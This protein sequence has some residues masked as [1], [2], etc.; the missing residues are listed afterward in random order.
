[1]IRSMT[2]YGKAEAVLADKKLIIEIK[3]LN[4]KSNDSFVKLPNAYRSKEIELRQIIADRLIRGKIDVNFSQELNTELSPAAIN[5]ELVIAYYKQLEEINREM[6]IS[7]GINLLDVV[8][9]LP[10]AVKVEK[11]EAD[12]NEWTLILEALNSAV[13]QLNAFREREGKSLEKDILANLSN[14]LKGLDEVPKYE[15]ARIT[16]IREK[17]YSQLQELK[18]KEGDGNNRLE[19]ELI[20]YLEKMDITEEKVRLRHHCDYFLET[21]KSEENAGK[22][23]GFIAQEMGREINTLGSKASDQDMQKIVVNM[24]DDLEKIKEQILNIL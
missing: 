11:N 8:M 3:S 22:K 16:R 4:S 13:D 15:G 21:I 18:L 12:E 14:I 20:F 19:Q 9:K 1:M 24:K 23:L 7:T 5:R 6:G 17:L 10:D 2:G